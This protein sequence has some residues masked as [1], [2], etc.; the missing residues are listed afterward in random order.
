MNKSKPII[1]QFPQNFDSTGTLSLP[2][3]RNQESS[4]FSHRPEVVDLVDDINNFDRTLIDSIV[5]PTKAPA[6]KPTNDVQSPLVLKNYSMTT[7][8]K[9]RKVNQLVDRRSPS[10]KQSFT[11]KRTTESIVST[12]PSEYIEKPLSRSAKK[13]VGNR[14]RKIDHQEFYIVNPNVE[15]QRIVYPSEEKVPHHPN[16][17]MI[18]PLLQENKA[19]IHSQVNVLAKSFLSTLSRLL[20][21]PK[22]S[23]I[24]RLT[25]LCADRD[26]HASC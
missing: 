12:T 4:R 6:V 18:N 15:N 5:K 14:N 11:S 25:K 20:L 1:Q 24:R 22:M 10:I 16:M 3:F 7:T 26:K 2:S 8:N 21:F 13:N 19:S 17:I 9:N 23:L